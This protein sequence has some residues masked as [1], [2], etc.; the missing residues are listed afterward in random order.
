MDGWT[1]REFLSTL[2]V[3]GM[4][5]AMPFRD[6][7]AASDEAIPFRWEVP[8]AHKKLVEA[9]LVYEGEVEADKSKGVVW[10]FVGLVLLPYLAQSVLKLIHQMK[11]GGIIIDAR[12][13]PVEIITDKSLPNGWIIVIQSDG[14][15]VFER[16]EIENPGALVKLLLKGT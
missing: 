12:N 6:V 1:R 5:L 16:G 14:K 2:G 9:S 3:W 11:K 13:S 8:E 7:W 15:T 10:I 4:G